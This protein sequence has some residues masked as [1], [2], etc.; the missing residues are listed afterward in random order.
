MVQKSLF[1]GLNLKS[2][3]RR[4]F[5]FLAQNFFRI[6]FDFEFAASKFQFQSLRKNCSTLTWTPVSQSVCQCDQIELF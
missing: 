5:Y 3:S 1:F 6:D 2:S 4:L